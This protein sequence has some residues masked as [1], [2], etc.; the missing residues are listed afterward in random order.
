[1][2]GQLTNSAFVPSPFIGVQS[3]SHI[4]F[5]TEIK[6]IWFSCDIYSIYFFHFNFY[7]FQENRNIFI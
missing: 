3:V 7:T 6:I 1:M 2:L 5:A 4:R